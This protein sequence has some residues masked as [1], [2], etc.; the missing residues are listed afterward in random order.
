MPNE[1]PWLLYEATFLEEP[2]GNLGCQDSEKGTGN[3]AKWK[4]MPGLV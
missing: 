2:A 4:N 3:T 1:L